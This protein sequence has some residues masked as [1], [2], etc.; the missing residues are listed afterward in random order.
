M[1]YRLTERTGRVV[2]AVA[3]VAACLTAAGHGVV[4]VDAHVDSGTEAVGLAV[5][6]AGPG[7]DAIRPNPS[8]RPATD[9]IRIDTD[10]R[11]TVEIVL[12]S[13][14]EG[15]SGYYFEVSLSGSG[16]ARIA[17]ASYP[18]AFGLT[19]PPERTTDGGLALE[20]ADLD[21]AV[22]AGATDVT[23]ATVTIV[24]NGSGTTRLVLDPVQ[25]DAD[26][27]TRIAPAATNAT[28]AVGIATAESTTAATAEST[29]AATAVDAGA[30]TETTGALPVTV[31]LAGLAAATLLALARGR[32]R[33]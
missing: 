10:G 24:G 5:D 22:D 28:V 9:P 19:T 25:F 27:G 14:P 1:T 13:V 32:R 30:T 2:L 7:A 12:T 21:G 33:T 17:N 15:L 4:A 8:L 18:D 11:T 6:D 29:T 20:A 23:V 31:V 3:L 26:S 16:V